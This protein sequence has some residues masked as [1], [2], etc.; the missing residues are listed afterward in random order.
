[1]PLPIIAN[2]VRAAVV[3]QQTNGQPWVN[4][5]HFR[6]TSGVIDAAALAALVTEIAKLYGG[7]AY[8]GGAVHMLNNTPL[9]TTTSQVVCTPL[10]GA[11]AS[12]ILSMALTG[13][14]AT[15]L[16]D[17]QAAATVTLQTGS[18]GRSFRGRMFLP[19]LHEGSNSSTGG[20]S[21]GVITGYN[22]QLEGFRAALAA[23]N[24]QWVVA[25]YL[26]SLATTVTAAIVRPTFGHQVRRRS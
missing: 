3:G 13:A 16:L 18:R 22:L 6:K 8:V 4:V 26:R 25:S 2:T 9:T 11:S 17:A 23:I 14:G 5:L 20:V 19:A 15:D 24:W 21:S 7:P 12:T 1:M 10:D